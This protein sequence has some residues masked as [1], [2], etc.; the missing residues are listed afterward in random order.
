MPGTF[1]LVTF[2]WICYDKLEVRRRVCDT[3]VSWS[4]E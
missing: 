2:F 3:S 4:H 1:F